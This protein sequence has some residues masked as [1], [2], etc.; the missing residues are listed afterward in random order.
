[1]LRK[2]DRTARVSINT[3]PFVIRLGSGTT[4]SCLAHTDHEEMVRLLEVWSNDGIKKK[5]K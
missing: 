3:Q 1:M 4:Q 5:K 2:Q